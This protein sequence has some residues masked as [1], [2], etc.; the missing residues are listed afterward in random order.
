MK[1]SSIFLPDCIAIHKVNYQQACVLFA[2]LYANF[3]NVT[4]GRCSHIVI[5][6]PT[7]NTVICQ[8]I[9]FRYLFYA[10]EF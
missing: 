2:D 4:N 8:V 6:Y 7:C 10:N 9:C 5:Q 3:L 1:I